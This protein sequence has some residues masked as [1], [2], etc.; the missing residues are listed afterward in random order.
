[1]MGTAQHRRAQDLVQTTLVPLALAFQP[2]HHIRIDA[3]GQ[4]LLDRTVELAALGTLPF[5]H[6]QGR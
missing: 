5:I 1:M 2:G 6:L 4:L 3:N